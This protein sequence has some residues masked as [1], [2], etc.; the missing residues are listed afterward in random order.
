MIPDSDKYYC[1]Q[2]YGRMGWV[3]VH[4]ATGGYCNWVLV[5]SSGRIVPGRAG[6]WEKYQQAYGEAISRILLQHGESS[7]SYNCYYMP[8]IAYGTPTTTR[9][10]RE[11]DG[12]QK[13]V[14]NAIL[15]KMGITSKAPRS[16]VFGMVW[17]GGIGLDHLAAAQSHMQLQYLIGHLRCQ[18]TTG[19]LIRMMM[20]FIQMECGCT[21][22]IFEQSYKQYAGAIIDENWIKAIWVHL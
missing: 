11:C 13:T 1:Y 5:R 22:N 4:N 17:Y 10:F 6:S 3:C 18:D 15:P 8:S 16:V 2:W 20:E 21:G 9:S 14:V 7:T 12:L 19:K